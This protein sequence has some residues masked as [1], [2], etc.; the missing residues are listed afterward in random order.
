M[1]RAKNPRP[2][3]SWKPPGA[4][5]CA[6]KIAARLKTPI[7]ACKPFAPPA[8]TPWMFAS[9][10]RRNFRSREQRFDDFALDISKAIIAALKTERQ[11]LVIESEQ[12]Q[13][14]RLQ[15]MDMHLV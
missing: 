1:S 4:S 7:S 15:V 2:I 14:R 13:N 5:A 11:P 3:F 8:W 6:R 9:C 12:V 10:A